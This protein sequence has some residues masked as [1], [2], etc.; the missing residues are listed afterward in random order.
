MSA[1]GE[2]HSVPNGTGN[3]RYAE[4]CVLGEVHS[5]HIGTGRCMDIQSNGYS[6]GNTPIHFPYCLVESSRLPCVILERQSLH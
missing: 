1:R 3:S 2:V 4:I 6:Q 5:V